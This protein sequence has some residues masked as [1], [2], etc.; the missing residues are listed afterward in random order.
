MKNKIIYSSDEDDIQLN[1]HDKVKV[2]PNLFENQSINSNLNLF[3][4]EN[5]SSDYDIPIINKPT[6]PS[7]KDR[8]QITL[9]AQRA[10]RELQ[11]QLPQKKSDVNIKNFLAKKGIKRDDSLEKYVQAL[12][13]VVDRS[14]NDDPI[15]LNSDKIEFNHSNT[16]KSIDNMTPTEKDTEV[17]IVPE[18]Q[19]I[20][21]PKMVPKIQHLVPIERGTKKYSKSDSDSDIEEIQIITKSTK[22][23]IPFFDTQP[24]SLTMK[25][26]RNRQMLELAKKQSEERRL[27]EI[28]LKR[29][30]LEELK[31]KRLERKKA[32]A[33]ELAQKA[34]EKQEDE[35]LIDNSIMV[36]DTNYEPTLDAATKQVDESITIPQTIEDGTN[37]QPL[38]NDQNEMATEVSEQASLSI[39][40]E[41]E[42]PHLIHLEYSI[43]DED[44]FDNTQATQKN[45]DTPQFSYALQQELKRNRESNT[46]EMKHT[47]SQES[48]S[49][50]KL[51]SQSLSQNTQNK[52]EFT[53][54]QFSSNNL[55]S[56]SVEDSQVLPLLSGGFDSTFPDSQSLPAV[57][58]S[59][60]SSHPS[61]LLPLLSGEFPPTQPDSISDEKLTRADSFASTND[62]QS[63]FPILPRGHSNTQ[64]S[65]SIDRSDTVLSLLSGTFDS[66]P[67][68]VLGN[69]TCT[70]EA[71]VS[72]N[73]EMG[74]EH[75]ANVDE[76]ISANQEMELENVVNA[77]IVDESI[78]V[79]QEMGLK[80]KGESF[81]PQAR[82]ILDLIDDTESENEQEQTSEEEDQD[83][84][85]V[86][87]PEIELES[88]PAKTI[89]QLPWALPVAKP[90][91][92]QTK[93]SKFVETEAEVEEDEFMNYGGLDGDDKGED[94][95]DA[96]MVNDANDED[97]DLQAL[98]ELHHQ[99]L[100]DQDAIDVNALIN[101]VTSGALRKRK[102]GRDESG[103]GLDLYDSDEEGEAILR[104]IR[105]QMGFVGSKKR[106]VDEDQSTLDALASN[107]MTQAFAECFIEKIETSGFLSS[108]H[109]DEDNIQTKVKVPKSKRKYTRTD[110]NLTE[111]PLSQ[112]QSETS[113]LFSIPTNCGDEILNSMIERKLNRSKSETVDH[114]L[115]MLTKQS[116]LVVEESK[117]YSIDTSDTI[118]K[119]HSAFRIGGTSNQEIESQPKLNF[120]GPVKKRKS[121]GSTSKEKGFSGLLDRSKSFQ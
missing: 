44:I 63:I 30:E 70:H 93:G 42:T 88:T 94:R 96:A 116:I 2:I 103:K 51:F 114:S 110:S 16:D 39:D 80:N 90:V 67:E 50:D 102:A 8:I 97:L 58:E 84:E 26:E 86:V 62:S 54:N 118:S 34:L 35:E 18:S 10:L 24:N 47:E 7:K 13:R 74:L 69:G 9:A 36:Q 3:N 64:K 87:E 28:E 85:S 76:S 98:M 19:E 112:T 73:K 113:S 27:A 101:D 37:P 38:A 11:L 49:K 53:S 17:L 48:P 81:E 20:I 25:M 21:I 60:A 115:R 65:Y 40:E 31:K 117:T 5:D 56:L 43:D 106:V 83:T 108:G 14:K 121:V 111:I 71:S 104:R 61:Q 107:P 82:C 109:E 72:V 59:T 22:P 95:Y 46:S 75:G 52:S 55:V 41:R 99:Q 45:N 77:E 23:K 100:A 12:Q 89:F 79:E 4:N 1:D 105:Q 57:Q 92:P 78:P 33:L 91:K 6:K 15:N 119:S 66:V 68:E 29:L 120:E 32:R